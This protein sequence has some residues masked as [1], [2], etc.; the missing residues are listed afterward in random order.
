MSTRPHNLPP[1]IYNAN[2]GDKEPI[3]CTR[4]CVPFLSMFRYSRETELLAQH[5]AA[6]ANATGQQCDRIHIA[7]VRPLIPRVFSHPSFSDAH[8]FPHPTFLPSNEIWLY[9][10][11]LELDFRKPRRVFAKRP[12]PSIC[13]AHFRVSRFATYMCLDICVQ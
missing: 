9:C 1:S 4:G 7:R 5:T 8:Q 10:P 3:R 13:L 2:K 12:A 6:V 11:N